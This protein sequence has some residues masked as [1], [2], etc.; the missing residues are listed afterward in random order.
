MKNAS[1]VVV[2]SIINADDT[3]YQTVCYDKILFTGLLA[4]SEALRHDCAQKQTALLCVQWKNR[5]YW[6]VLNE[7]SKRH[8][9]AICVANKKHSLPFTGLLAVW[10]VRHLGVE[11]RYCFPSSHFASACCR[12]LRCASLWPSCRLERSS[13]LTVLPTPFGAPSFLS[14]ATAQSEWLTGRPWNWPALRLAM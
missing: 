3:E 7:K 6:R 12:L 5:W 9:V 4:A 14:N 11:R 2:C 8:W 10:S 13:Q 1:G